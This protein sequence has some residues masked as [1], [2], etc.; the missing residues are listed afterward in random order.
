M[1]TRADHSAGVPCWID[2]NQPAPTAAAE[3]SSQEFGWESEDTLP[4]APEGRKG[5]PRMSTVSGLAFI[6]YPARDLDRAIGA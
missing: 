4:S 2:S 1:S 5:E 6:I 3:F